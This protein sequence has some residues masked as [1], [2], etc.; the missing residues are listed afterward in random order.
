MRH[1]RITQTLCGYAH[2]ESER[3]QYLIARTNAKH[4]SRSGIIDASGGPGLRLPSPRSQAA[5][6]LTSRPGQF[7]AE[8]AEAPRSVRLESWEEI[9]L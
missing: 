7:G 8:Y 5:D 1:H 6:G 9:F 2:S 4:L 3:Q